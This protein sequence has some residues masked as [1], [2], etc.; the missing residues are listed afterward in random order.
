MSFVEIAAHCRLLALSNLLFQL[1]DN[2]SNERDIWM[3]FIVI[4][5]AFGVRV[6]CQSDSYYG[7]LFANGSFE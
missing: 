7:K 2:H 6:T 4:G 1:P 3:I 5:M